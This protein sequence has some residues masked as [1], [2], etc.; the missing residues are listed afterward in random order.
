MGI[1]WE[2]M[3]KEET[4]AYFSTSLESHESVS[5]VSG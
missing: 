1:D 3:W 2:G 5:I 4:A